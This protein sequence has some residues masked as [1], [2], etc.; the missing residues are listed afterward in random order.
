M[1]FALLGWNPAVRQLLTAIAASPGDSLIAAAEISVDAVQ[2]LISISADTRVIG[3][4]HGLLGELKVDAF[5]VVGSAEPILDGARQLAADGRPVVLIPEAAQGTAF[6]Y[7]LTLIQNDN[8]VPLIPIPALKLRPAARRLKQ[9]IDAGD[10]GEILLIRIDRTITAI[11]AGVLTVQEIDGAMLE[12]VAL[13]RGLGGNYNHVTAVNSE[14]PDGGVSLATVTLGGDG[15]AEATWTAR[16]GTDEWNLT[17]TGSSGTA[18]L[19]SGDSVDDWQ[20]EVTRKGESVEV[21]RDDVSSAG[22]AQLSA[23]VQTPEQLY[24]DWAE[25]TR[26]FES[27]EATHTSIRRRRTIDLYFEA[28]S[29]RSIFKSQMTAVGCGLIML[30]LFSLVAFLLLGAFLDSRSMVQRSAQAEGRVI[31]PT[32]FVP[33]T[34]ELTDSGANHLREVGRRITRNPGP[35]FVVPDERASE[36]DNLTARRVTAVVTLFQES[37]QDEAALFVEPAE[38]AHPLVVILLAVLKYLWIIPLVV[39]LI[40]Q[41][42]IVIARPSA[43]SDS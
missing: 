14:A 35:I 40:L 12:D 42:L 5:L 19:Q 22:A 43:R 23:I 11:G 3:D 29:E 27:V 39:F 18:V 1:K 32:E 25:I 33:G 2:D 9:T 36:D 4:R 15:L 7:E 10:L 24:S 8:G 16:A 34:A 21:T 30:T 6:L 26:C 37:G 38:V 31:Q 28:A 41:A 13:L 17:V 20:L